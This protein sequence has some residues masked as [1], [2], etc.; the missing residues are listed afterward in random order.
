MKICVGILAL[1]GSSWRSLL[2][3]IGVPCRLAEGRLALDHYSAVVV[4]DDAGT[5]A[6]ASAR[7]YLRAGGAL[8]CSG[9]IHALLTGT[10]ADCPSLGYLLQDEPGGSFPGIGLVDIS[11]PCAVPAGANCVRAADGRPSVLIGSFGA[12]RIIALPFDV[13]SLLGDRRC[14]YKSFWADRRRLPFEYVSHVS[15]GGVRK[16]AARA[17]ELLHHQRGLPFLHLWHFPGDERSLFAFRIDTDH[18]TA[19][20]IDSLASLLR[21]HDIPATWFVHVGAQQ[22]LLP[23]FASLEGHEVGVHCFEHR[24]FSDAEG[25]DRDLAKAE[26]ALRAAGIPFTGYAGPY[27]RWSMTL[28]RALAR[29]GF[30]YSSEFSYD[31]DNLPSFPERDGMAEP[32]LQVPV[33]PMS[34]GNLRRQGC[35]PAEMQKYFAGAVDRMLG[36]GDPVFLYHHPKNLHPEVLGELFSRVREEKIATILIGEYARWWKR[37]LSLSLDAETDGDLV[38]LSCD[39]ADGSMRC[40]MTRADGT[41]S[42]APAGGAVDARSLAWSAVRKPVPLPKGVERTRKFNPWIPINRM[43]DALHRK[44]FS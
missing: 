29:H 23:R 1:D 9:R 17:L 6:L 15:R 2:R 32:V 35:T 3:Q 33:H 19:Q 31:Y 26:A 8:L 4:A 14:T 20:E 25:I 5:E 28:A 30:E 12:G 39:G 43:E 21:R 22:D 34:I 18:G 41:E 38:R 37:R 13:P 16:L 36:I 42:W 10:A 7:E 24:A 11:A 27:G 40:R 44:L